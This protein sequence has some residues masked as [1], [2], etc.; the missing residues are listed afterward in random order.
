MRAAPAG[1]TRPADFLPS[2]GAVGHT[3]GP[4]TSQP[5]LCVHIAPLQTP[6][7]SYPLLLRPFSRM[8]Y[9]EVGG[10]SCS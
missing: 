8:E 4:C 5:P 2:G 10:C 6:V 7:I 9:F 3:A 1:P